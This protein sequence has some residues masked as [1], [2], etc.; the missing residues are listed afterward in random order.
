MH[1]AIPACPVTV[2]AQVNGVIFQASLDMWKSHNEQLHGAT[3][4]E[5]IN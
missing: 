1:I 4:E 3:D 2:E 5:N